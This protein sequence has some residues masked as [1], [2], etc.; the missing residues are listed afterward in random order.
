MFSFSTDLRARD[1][2]TKSHTTIDN[3]NTREKKGSLDVSTAV[4]GTWTV[5]KTNRVSKFFFFLYLYFLFITWSSSFAGLDQSLGSGNEDTPKLRF[6]ISKLKKKRRKT[7]RKEKEV[8]AKKRRTRREPQDTNTAL[9]L[10]VLRYFA[11]LFFSLKLRPTPHLVPP[12]LAF[13]SRGKETH[14]KKG[15][16]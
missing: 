14:K 3:K 8:A 10:V 4:V 1:T 15:K 11:L 12:C 13:L 6:T 5:S 2:Q 7:Y 9:C 16:C